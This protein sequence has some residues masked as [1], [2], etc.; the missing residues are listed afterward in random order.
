[1]LFEDDEDDEEAD[2]SQI[3]SGLDGSSGALLS[4]SSLDDGL[5][6]VQEAPGGIEEAEQVADGLEVTSVSERIE[7]GLPLL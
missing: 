7:R 4:E 2:Q 1:M 3:L 6:E 5:L